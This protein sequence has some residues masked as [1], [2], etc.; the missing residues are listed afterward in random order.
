M[1]QTEV[2]DKLRLS[3]SKV[4]TIRR[5]GQEYIWKYEEGLIPKEKSYPLKLG[6]IVH[7]ILHMHDQK[8]IDVDWV[9][10]FEQVFEMV[11]ERYPDEEPDE[12]LK[13][14]EQ[15]ITLCTGYLYAHK[16]D[17]VTIIPGETM[18]E[19]E[20]DDYILLGIPDGWARPEDGKLFR[21][22]RKTSAKID[23]YYLNGLKGGLQGAIYD[24][25]TET[26]FKEPLQGTIYDMLVKTKEPKFPRTF[27]KCDRTSISLMKR[28]LEGVVKDIKERNLYPDPNSCF[29]Y[30]SECPY[31]VL[32]TFDSQAARDNFFTKRKEENGNQVKKA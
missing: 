1:T 11:N 7:H 15:S 5:C 32:C 27:T 20:Y 29:R 6:D 23:N 2:T 12:L 8:E 19:I 25:I 21:L 28:C 26:L 4:N 24:H 18:L 10:D 30:N 9:Q 14:T 3:Y 13:L 16:D 22:E 17:T 31:R